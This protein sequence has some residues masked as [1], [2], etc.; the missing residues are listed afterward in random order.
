ME[1]SAEFDTVFKDFE[2]EIKDFEELVVVELVLLVDK[3]EY[4]LEIP[5]EKDEITIEYVFF[6][7]FQLIGLVAVTL[8]FPA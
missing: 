4:L 6:L 7:F 1:L 3:V 2:L 8:W 5:L